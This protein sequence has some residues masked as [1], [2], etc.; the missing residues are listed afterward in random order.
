MSCM[1]SQFFCLI[2]RRKRRQQQETGT[3]ARKKKNGIKLSRDGFEET[4]T[5]KHSQSKKHETIAT[6]AETNDTS[7]I[8]SDLFHGIPWE[9]GVQ[10]YSNDEV[11]M[12]SCSI[13][14][15]PSGSFEANEK[16]K[17]PSYQS[18]NDGEIGR[19]SDEGDDDF[20]RVSF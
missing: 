1:L 2:Q 17:K 19:S 10:E 20:T 3:S 5:F 18:S 9:V 15:G 14:R 13:I 7:N 8:S 12:I 11:S 16:W 4:E 6:P